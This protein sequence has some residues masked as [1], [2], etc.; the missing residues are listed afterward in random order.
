MLLG[1]FFFFWV[2]WVTLIGVSPKIFKTHPP[3]PKQK[4]ELAYFYAILH[5][6][7]K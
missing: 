4:K 1:F 5:G 3:P 2:Q 7:V 6:H